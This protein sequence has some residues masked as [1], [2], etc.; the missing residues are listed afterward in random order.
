MTHIQSTAEA[1]RLSDALDTLADAIEWIETADRCMFCGG[2]PL[3]LAELLQVVSRAVQAT[4]D[5]LAREAL[6]Q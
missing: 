3:E 6:Q 2:Y 1:A 5:E 4:H